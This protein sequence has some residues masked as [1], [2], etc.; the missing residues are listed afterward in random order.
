MVRKRL[1]NGEPGVRASRSMAAEQPADWWSRVFALVVDY[2]IVLA[3]SLGWGLLF[4]VNVRARFSHFPPG[5]YDLGVWAR[6][7]AASVLAAAMYFPAIMH[8][9]RGRTL[10]KA[11][12]GVRV[13]RADGSDITWKR[14]LA[15][16]AVVKAALFYGLPFVGFALMLVDSLWP[17]RDSSHRALHDFVAGTRVVVRQSAE[18]SSI[19]K[20]A[21]LG[22]S[23]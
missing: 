17:L 10:G 9:T 2:A 18:P 16:E 7:L 11:L 13:V 6:A 5:T 12:V 20:N 8:L 3:L 21:G 15:R 4:G 22:L 14:A 1:S 19:S 23:S